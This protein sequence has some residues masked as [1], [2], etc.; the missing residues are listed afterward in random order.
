MG[1][2]KHTEDKNIPEWLKSNLKSHCI[3]DTEKENYYNDDGNCTSRRCPNKQCPLTLSQKISAMCDVL[4]VKGVAE[5]IGMKLVIEKKLTTHFDAIK[6]IFTE[7]PIITLYQLL[8][9]TFIEG[10]DTKWEAVCGSYSSVDELVE[11]YNGD[12]RHLILENLDE[13]KYGESCV[14]IFKP[15]KKQFEPLIRGT[16]VLSG[17]FKGFE[18]RNNFI[19]GINH[20]SKGLIDLSISEY[21]RKTGIICVI[22]EKDEPIRGKAE[23]AIEAGI[24][25]KTPDEFKT[26]I[27]NLL[28]E[29]LEERTR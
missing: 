13:I 5:G 3:C 8:R 16:V 10:V 4:G 9:I 12:L 7:K 17:H 28:K 18:D 14:E 11:G 26:Y 27:M 21:K 25:I 20:F 24:P 19:R 29:R 23:A 22:Q 2:V 1:W 15:V 6:Y